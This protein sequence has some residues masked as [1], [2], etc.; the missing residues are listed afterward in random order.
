MEP[1]T[2]TISSASSVDLG[3]AL[4]YWGKANPAFQAPADYHPLPYHAMDVAAVGNVYLRASPALLGYFARTLAL[5]ENACRRWLV[6]WLA[7]HDL[8]KFATSFQNQRPDLL[9][10]LQKRESAR[11]YG[12]RHDT[13]GL[14]LWHQ[15]L[16]RHDPL[17]VGTAAQRYK[18]RLL[19]WIT[20]VTGH[21][22][23]PPGSAS[24]TEHFDLCDETAAAAF[25]GAARSLLLP[26][27]D[28]DALLTLP[29]ER[30]G[31]WRL[32]W[33]VSGIAVLA[34]WLGSNT[35][36]FPYCPQ[37]LSLEEYWWY[38]QPQAER[39][40]HNSGVLPAASAP[41]QK[42]SVLFG[43]D[44]LDERRT[45]TPLQAWAETAPLAKTPQLFLLEDVTGAGKTEAALALAQRLMASGQANGLFVGL[46]T[47]AT[48]NAMY[49]RIA[50][51]APRLF[52]ASAAPSMTLAHARRGLLSTF[53]D[54]VL[55]NPEPEIDA[56][57]TLDETASARCTA[58]LA[59]SNKKA[60]LANVGVGTLDQALL[61]VLHAR[62]QSL[63]LLGLFGK[64]L[65]VDE[66]H[67][68]DAYMQAVLERLL[69][70]H[71]AGGGNIILLSATLPQHMKQ[72]LVQAW[73][74]GGGVSAPVLRSSDYPLATQ[75][76]AGQAEPLEQRLDTRPEVQRRVAVEYLSEADE[77]PARIRMALAEGRCVCW[78]RNTVADA[79]AAWE[80]LKGVG[81]DDDIT[82]FHARFA[83]G[84]RLDIE[85]QVIN[86]FGPISGPDERRGKL[87][88]ATQV[89]EQSLDVDFDLLISDLAPIDRLIQRAGRLQRHAR[90][91]DGRRIHG[92]DGR[93]GAS[94][95]VYGPAWNETPATDWYRRCFPG[96]TYV[97]PHTGQL[98]LTA[99]FLVD[100]R[101]F[102]M[103]EDARTWIEGVFGEG[104]QQQIPETL[105]QASVESEGRDYAATNLAAANR[106]DLAVGYRRIGQVDWAADGEAPPAAALDDWSGNAAKTR[107][108]EPTITVRLAR[109]DGLGLRP[110]RDDGDEDAWEA[111][112]LRLPARLIGT[113]VLSVAE[114]EAVE[115]MKEALPDRGRWSEL[116]PLREVGGR[117]KA[118]VR[119]AQGRLQEVSYGQV[120]GLTLR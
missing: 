114:T 45:S 73:A 36:Y 88:I 43:W 118:V 108:G 18:N 22:G 35:D 81:P 82:L 117:W 13:L 4:A 120:P 62:H 47:M 5:H 115:R 11:G 74:A 41:A 60:L 55:P 6:L 68:C 109:W 30:L 53:R 106:L 95:L 48:A 85:R 99:R 31:E 24:L 70:F 72:A 75:V 25:V 21:H 58:W 100:W 57:Q 63:R 65:I 78:I 119:N 110:W 40:V 51:I 98:W 17:G 111:S 9:L 76:A 3:G 91:V 32:S 37:P 54:S 44:H 67:A 19:P 61:G 38:I 96:G 27:T 97:Y 94:L 59:D 102:S 20:A 14:T 71:A 16:A 80:T 34:D 49:E 69:C 77:V 64:V 42:L 83:M 87:V 112:S 39:A 104:A 7:L 12:A 2:T 8:G 116:L 15:L 28:R 10:R 84:D 107:L 79:L 89:I 90:A 105:R 26:D 56:R 86:D 33:W 46:P 92:A 93:G 50:V 52:T 29:A 103:P 1:Q 101:G 113:L 66:V 23:Q